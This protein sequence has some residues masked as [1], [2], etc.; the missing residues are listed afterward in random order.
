[1]EAIEQL[2]YGKY[3]DRIKHYTIFDHILQR[4][5]S[6]VQEDTKNIE[7]RNKFRNI[8]KK[9]KEEMV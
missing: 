2:S 7:I 6:L 3:A 4:I 8:Y 5:F 1:M 9:M